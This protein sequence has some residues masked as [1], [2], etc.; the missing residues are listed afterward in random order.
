[1]YRSQ[2]REKLD[3]P[4]HCFYENCFKNFDDFN[5]LKK[6]L[7]EHFER[8][9]VEEKARAERRKRIEE[10]LARQRQRREMEKQREEELEGDDNTGAGVVAHRAGSG[11]EDFGIGQ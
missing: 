1:M 10:Q 6:H 2:Y 8:I 7:K 3:E 4:L 9:S 11:V 5:S